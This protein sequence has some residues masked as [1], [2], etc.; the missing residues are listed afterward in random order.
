[1]A[2]ISVTNRYKHLF[3]EHAW[4]T[5]DPDLPYG[6]LDKKTAPGTRSVTFSFKQTPHRNKDDED[7]WDWPD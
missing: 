3:N 1:M 5:K 7:C 4:E 2:K 6:V